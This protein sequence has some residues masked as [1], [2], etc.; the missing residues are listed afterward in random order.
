[1]VK[2]LVSTTLAHVAQT[3]RA[4]NKKDPRLENDGKTF[5]ILQEQGRGYI[6]LG[7]VRKKQKKLPIMVLKK[8]MEVSITQEELALIHICI[9]AI[10][11]TMSSFEY[12]RYTH[13]EDSNRTK[14]LRLRNI[15]FKK[16]G[17]LL[18]HNPQLLLY[19][20]LV[21]ITF[22]SQKSNMRNKTDHMFKINDN[23]LC[24]VKSWTSAVTRI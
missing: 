15:R 20:D 16:N 24:P 21:A 18:D 1:M 11:F 22:E 3:F 8:M 6:N 10:S 7:K 5:I 19:A 4:N 13:R 14:V 12:L 9:G 2:G 17:I 23:L